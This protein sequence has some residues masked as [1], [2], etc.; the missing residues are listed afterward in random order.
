MDFFPELERIVV[1]K[2]T[3]L[4]VGLDPYFT[5]E[6]RA[7]LGDAECLSRALE[8][9]KRIIAATSPY[10][11]CY[12]P[13]AAFYE[14]FGAEGHSLL[15]KTIAAIPEWIPFIYDAKR[16]DIESTGKAYADAIFG[17][18]GANAVTLNPY[19]GREIVEPFLAYEGRGLF[20]LCKTSNP[21]A[22]AFQ[23]LDSG[24]GKL[25]ETVARTCVS[26]SER[27]GLVVAGNDPSALA[28]VRA[29]APYAWFLAPGIGAQGGRAEDA[30]T[31]GARK[32]GRGVLV[33][34]AR[35][36]AGAS[37]PAAAAASLRD[38]MA[39]IARK[40]TAIGPRNFQG[41]TASVA[42]QV[43][44]PNT[45]LKDRFVAG[46]LSTGCFRLGEFVLKSG[47]KSPFYID[48][49][50]LISDPAVL[51]AAAEAY[52]SLA[53]G[54][55]FDRLAGIPAAGL[56]LA[57]AAG[58]R[59]AVPMIWPRMPVKEHGTGNRIEGACVAGEKV[60]LLDD[61]ITTGAS[62]L[63]A[64]EILRGESLVVEDLVV[65]IERGKQGR[66]DMEAAGIRLHAF[67]H[68]R[69]LF[70]SCERQG[71]IDRTRREEL[72]RFVDS[73]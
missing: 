62:K 24:T 44:G 50:R 56:P 58:I 10:A 51:G 17:G 32:D 14:A 63:E 8:A 54:I 46:L 13:N 43:A 16:G 5:R 60:L 41:F 21:G 67:L 35:S 9:N 36:V 4:C 15:E 26:W 1:D 12:K 18:L 31:A 30:I 23:G 45:E 27:I 7:S 37:D 47:K 2:G 71:L 22:G 6:E 65:L 28:C 52:S 73:E 11:A 61:L 20:L 29:A 59:L 33:V 39:A 42:K 68:V 3:C 64:V 25:Y 70:D 72:E 38:Q 55:G 48:L 19:M 57:T 66:R 49:R 34:A 40:I 69:E 53:S